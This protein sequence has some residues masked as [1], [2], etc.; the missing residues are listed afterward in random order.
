MAAEGLSRMNAG[1]YT[2]SQGRH[3]ALAGPGPMIFGALL[4]G[5]FGF[6]LGLTPNNSAGHFVWLFAVFLWTLR[7]VAIGNAL[8]A[9]VTFASPLPGNVLYGLVGVLSA[10]AFVILAVWDILDKT[11]MLYGM[12][13]LPA[14]MMLLLFAAWN[15]YGS[16]VGLQAV[17]TLRR[18]AS[19]ANPYETKAESPHDSDSLDR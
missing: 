12:P 14:W 4:F 9:M 19:S 5:Y 2:Y 6:L 7:V 8:S 3:P 18:L 13:F 17:M 1:G 11:Y 16:W 10:V 15:G